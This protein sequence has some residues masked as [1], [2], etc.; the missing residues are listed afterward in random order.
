MDHDQY[1]TLREVT[2][3][4]GTPYNG[5][6]ERLRPKGIPFSGFRY[7]KGQ[8]PRNVNMQRMDP[9]FNL[10][11]FNIYTDRRERG[12]GVGGNMN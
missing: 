12:G 1:R 6:M 2:V 4:E 11:I 3:P 5:H 8:S 9:Y 7:L 10:F